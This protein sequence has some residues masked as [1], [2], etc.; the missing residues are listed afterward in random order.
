VEDVEGVLIKLRM[1]EVVEEEE[2]E[3]EYC[4]Y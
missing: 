3:E 2:I 4:C 1:E